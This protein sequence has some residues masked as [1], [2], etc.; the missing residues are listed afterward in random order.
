MFIFN[1]YRGMTS[2]IFPPGGTGKDEKSARQILDMFAPI[3]AR[4]SSVIG[5]FTRES[6]TVS[7]SVN[8]D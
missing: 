6:T 5:R 3:S 4:C 2:L 1:E 8:V 7:R